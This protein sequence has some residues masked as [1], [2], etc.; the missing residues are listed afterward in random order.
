MKR[1]FCFRSCEMAHPRIRARGPGGQ[2]RSGAEAAPARLH[3]RSRDLG[4]FPL[5]GADFRRQTLIYPGN[6]GALC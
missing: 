2:C 1:A 5:M 3:V 4:E 6:E